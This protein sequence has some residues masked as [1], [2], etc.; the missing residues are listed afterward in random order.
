MSEHHAIDV[1]KHVRSYMIVFASLMVL[2]IVTVAVSYLDVSVAA[3]I[4]LGLVIA[5]VKASLVAAVFMHL[6]DEKKVI[7]WMLVCTL[8]AFF[9]LL[10]VPY[11][12]SVTDQVGG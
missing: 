10:L 11:W 4:A 6:I 1:D 9:V 7:Y 12:T 5:T 2:T 3:A 8:A